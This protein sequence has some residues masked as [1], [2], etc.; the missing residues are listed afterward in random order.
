M[1]KLTLIAGAAGLTFVALAAI[2]SPRGR[3]HGLGPWAA[4]TLGLSDDQQTRVEAVRESCAKSA[5]PLRSQLFEK[6]Q[7]LKA[8]WAEATPDAAQIRA[9]QKEISQLQDQLQD[10][11]VQ[12]RLDARTIL[13]PEQQQ[14]LASLEQGKGC[15]GGDC[16]GRDCGGPDSRRGDRGGPGCREG[17][18]Q[19]HGC[20][21]RGGCR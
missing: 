20:D 17:D 14:K 9:K 7:E 13:T 16:R 10:Q 6:R 8:L 18:R 2:A 11:S 4:A 15:D 3:G 19:G 12:C 21:K 5:S 1:K